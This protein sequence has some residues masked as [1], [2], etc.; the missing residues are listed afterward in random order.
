MGKDR[1]GKL[2]VMLNVNDSDLK[3]P[4]HDDLCIWVNNNIKEILYK[5]LSEKYK[6]VYDGRFEHYFLNDKDSFKLDWEE[7]LK[8]PSN[9]F[10]VGVPDFRYSIC[11]ENSKMFIGGYIEVKPSIKSIRETMRQ[12]KLYYSY[13]KNYK[14]CSRYLNG[15]FDIKEIEYS[16]RPC[17][18]TD[19]ILVTNTQEF[20]EIFE[21]QGIICIIPG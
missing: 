6:V 2:D 3:T 1:S 21:E 20:K 19:I 5:R 12:L 18:G 4:K 17:F 15:L 14:Q 11:S 16:H 10:I 7:P 13:I 8:A 9:G